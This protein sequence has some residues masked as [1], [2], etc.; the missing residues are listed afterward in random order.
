M[1]T[2]LFSILVMVQ[3]F[4][5]LPH[6][7]LAQATNGAIKGEVQDAQKADVPNASLTLKNEATGVVS[8]ATSGSSGQFSFPELSP[9]LY[10]LT[11]EAAGF[12]T[13]TQ[14]HL[15]AGGRWGSISRMIG[16]FLPASR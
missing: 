1:K 12:S 9:G 13:S 5:L 16:D 10:V 11:T 7:G 15:I 4:F 14:Q 8:R 2:T 6:P 3:V